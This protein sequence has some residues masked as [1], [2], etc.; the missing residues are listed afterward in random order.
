MPP[1]N[2]DKDGGVKVASGRE[3]IKQKAGPHCVSSVHTNLP[4]TKVL[5][6][7]SNH[8]EVSDLLGFLLFLTRKGVGVCVHIHSIMCT[9]L[10][11]LWCILSCFSQLSTTSTV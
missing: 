4:V 9:V 6:L 3:V 10:I 5:Q 8:H 2:E 11:R 1:L 7:Y